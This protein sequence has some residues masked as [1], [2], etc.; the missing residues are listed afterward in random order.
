MER[1]EWVVGEGLLDVAVVDGCFVGIIESRE[2][3]GL[4]AAH[5]ADARC[6]EVVQR[7]PMHADLGWTVG[8]AHEALDDGAIPTLAVVD[9]DRFSVW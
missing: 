2:A 9:G 1:F 8:D 3:I 5:G 7:D 6:D 4:L